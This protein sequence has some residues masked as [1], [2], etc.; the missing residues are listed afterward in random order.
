MAQQF[1][2]DGGGI[3]ANRAKPS[4]S[5]AAA[6][7][8]DEDRLSA[9]PDDVLVL[10]LLGLGTTAEAVQTSVLSRRWR[11]VWTLLPELRFHQVPD[12]GRRIREA[13]VAPDA[14]LPL[15]RISVTAEDSGPDSLQAWLPEVTRRLSGNLFYQ[16]MALREDVDED[17]AIQLPCFENATGVE[18]TLGFL[19]LALPFAGTFTRL[20]NLGL[21]RVRLHGPWL[22]VVAPALKE[23]KLFCCFDMCRPVAIISTPQLVLLDWSDS[24]DLRSVQ[25][26]KL[27]QLLRLRTD[28]FLVHGQHNL[29]HDR[30]LLK[31][32]QQFQF[33]HDLHIPLGYHHRRATCGL[34][35]VVLVT[36]IV[37]K[38]TCA[39]LH[40]FCS[41]HIRRI[42]K[43]LM[44]RSITL[45][46]CQGHTF[47]PSL[48]H[49][50]KLYTGIR[51]LSL[52]LFTSKGLES[53]CQSGCNCDQPT[54]WKAKGLLLNHLKLVDII[55][56]EV[57][58]NMRITLDFSVSESKARELFPILSSFSRPETR[59]ELYMCNSA[60]KRL[61][62]LLGPEDQG[63][64]L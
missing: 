6:I 36:V 37:L 2:G 44:V 58:K 26:G 1:C 61:V 62:F 48:I 33:I 42:S 50:L 23:L 8:S 17:E 57:L 47:G 54:N 41:A 15:R 28:V 35:R 21:Y 29:L 12:D 40:S 30:G 49:V 31:L 13:L 63:A 10:I 7:A 38:N 55:N 20:A 53:G 39:N 59:I 9:F 25:L 64:A 19:G 5:D 18:L 24:Y 34:D 11:R 22:T 27:G 56:P 45:V 4:S 32:L 43:I 3:A 51:R 52:V 16:N 14:P 46:T 60:D